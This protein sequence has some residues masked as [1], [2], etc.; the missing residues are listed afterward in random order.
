MP[1]ETRPPN[2][3][4]GAGGLFSTMSDYLRFSQMLL[5]GGE[6]GGVRLLGPKT[7]ELMTTDHLPDGVH[8]P[9][10]FGERYRLEGMVSG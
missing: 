10:R 1:A 6:L 5:N 2:A 7:V 9:V 8:L 3:P 4:D